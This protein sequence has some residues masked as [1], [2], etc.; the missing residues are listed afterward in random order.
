MKL[1]WVVFKFVRVDASLGLGEDYRTLFPM[2]DSGV[3]LFLC[4]SKATLKA[5]N[6][7]RS[8]STTLS[9]SIHSD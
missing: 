9:L 7:G 1:L 5:A 3:N 2:H 6:A 4:V 8:K